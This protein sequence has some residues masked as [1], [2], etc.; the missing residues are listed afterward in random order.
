MVRRTGVLAELRS[1]A[2]DPLGRLRTV[3]K[4]RRVLDEVSH[5]A[6]AKAREMGVSWEEIA[7][8]VGTS[9]QSVWERYR[10]SSPNGDAVPQVMRRFPHRKRRHLAIRDAISEDFGIVV[11]DRLA[12]ELAAKLASAKPRSNQMMVLLGRDK[13]TGDRIR[14]KVSAVALAIYLHP[15]P[16]RKR[17]PRYA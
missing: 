4:Y 9:R 15:D 16:L 10:K 3:A 17:Q 1:K 7:E 6:V 14:K 12:R 8:A 2:D 5:E 13:K 11:S